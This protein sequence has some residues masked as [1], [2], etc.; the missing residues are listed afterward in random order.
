MKTPFLILF[1]PAVL[2]AQT[3]IFY[4]KIEEGSGTT[5][6]DEIG[7]LVGTL[8]NMDTGTDWVAGRNGIGFGL[9]FDGVND[10]VDFND[11]LDFTA[12]PISI[13]AWVYPRTLGEGPS[14]RILDKFNNTTAGYT[15]LIYSTN[16]LRFF[17]GGGGADA[18]TNSV[19]LNAWN[20]VAVSWD[21]SNANFFVNGVAQGTP[22][23]TNVPIGNT[24]DLCIGNG[25]SE[26]R[27]F[28][29]VIDEV[30]IYNAA[31]SE[32]KIDSIYAA[33]ATQPS[34]SQPKPQT[35]PRWW[36]MLD[37]IFYVKVD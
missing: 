6:T 18:N 24:I 4:A 33:T 17:T 22:A 16:R 34:S 32:A 29:G 25:Q 37:K 11:V 23:V 12:A 9:D 3:P 21:G 1:L 27:T 14:G 8:T 10:R 30:L 15:F 36:G 7:S 5:T 26:D 19:T 35:R 13:C 2:L 28:D 20:H 31:L